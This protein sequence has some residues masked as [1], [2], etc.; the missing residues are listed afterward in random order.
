M[1]LGQPPRSPYSKNKTCVGADLRA[2]YIVSMNNIWGTVIQN[3]SCGIDAACREGNVFVPEPRNVVPEHFPR[4]LFQKS[5]GAFLV[6]FFRSPSTGHSAMS[7]PTTDKGAVPRASE[8]HPTAQQSRRMSG[9]VGFMLDNS[10]GDDL[11]TWFK[12]PE[13]GATIQ[14]LPQQESPT[15]AQVP[16]DLKRDALLYSADQYY[17]EPDHHLR[18]SI[19]L[20]KLLTVIFFIPASL[21]FAF[22][23]AWRTIFRVSQF[24]IFYGAMACLR[25]IAAKGEHR[26]I[27]TCGAGCRARK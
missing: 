17:K 2:H 12:K 14:P 19:W 7:L 21:V 25:R 24:E 27:S 26:T 6:G 18:P 1:W 11:E 20:M 8:T 9:F 22:S 16:E 15:Y 4:S 5:G 13:R 10:R 23:R 3:V